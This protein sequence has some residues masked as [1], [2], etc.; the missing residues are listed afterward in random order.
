[1]NTD[2]YQ[3]GKSVS[4]NNT[5]ITGGGGGT[6][7]IGTVSVAMTNK[8]S[9]YVQKGLSEISQSTYSYIIFL[10]N[11]KPKSMIWALQISYF[12]T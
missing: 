8:V 3:V 4:G 6:P 10:K 11:L 1:M 12:Y 5:S 2:V 9:T 7:P